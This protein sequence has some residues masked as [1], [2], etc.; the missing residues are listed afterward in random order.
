MR[1]RRKIVG[2]QKVSHAN[3]LSDG[4]AVVSGNSGSEVLWRFYSAGCS[5]GRIARESH[6]HSGLAGAQT[7]VNGCKA[8]PGTQTSIKS[9]G[10][11]AYWTMSYPWHVAVNDYNHMMPPHSV[12]CQPALSSV[13][14]NSAQPMSDISTH[15]PTLENERS[16]T[17]SH[18]SRAMRTLGLS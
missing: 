6:G 11:G 12:S 2:E 5:F 13:T 7:F 1:V 4:L 15:R 3:V 10:N 8:I 17:C 16:G 9:D 18:R 14:E